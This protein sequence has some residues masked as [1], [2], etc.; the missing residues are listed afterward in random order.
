MRRAGFLFRS[1]EKFDRALH[2][3]SWS[4]ARQSEGRRS[5]KHRSRKHPDDSALPSR[6]RV[7]AV[8]PV[9]ETR[10]SKPKSRL[11]QVRSNA[12]RAS[13][14]FGLTIDHFL[15]PSDSLRSQLQAYFLDLR[16]E[17]TQ[18]SYAKDLKRFLQFLAARKHKTGGHEPIHRG[19]L[20]AYKD[21]L[22]TEGLEHTTI[23]RFLSMLR[24]L[25]RFLFEEG[26]MSENPAI[27]VR[28]LSPKRVSKTQAFTDQEVANVI[29]Q[30]NLHTRTGA[31]HHAILLLLFQCGLR[32]SELCALRTSQITSERGY[33]VMRLR[34][35]GNAERVIPL[36][37]ES[38]AALEYYYRIC[39]MSPDV[40]QPLFRPQK[41]NRTGN[42][43]KSLD[44][45]HIY[46]IVT[47]YSLMAGV[48]KRVSPHSC[49]ATAIS[50]ARDHAAPDR[51]IQEFAGW[52]TP[53]MITQYDK[54]KTAVTE[55]A[56]LLIDYGPI[57]RDS[58]I[59]GGHA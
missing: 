1:L 14:E 38:I 18:K 20:V 5:K 11:I 27:R 25:F 34:G 46:H 57:A 33:K 35:K 7:R 42:K 15:N 39:Q 24:S 53:N 6:S 36:R 48:A 21:S 50:N 16:S 13:K 45:S 29:A 3:V 43:E 44:P 8:A 9:K 26:A 55:S 19:L 41:N 12:P 22:L 31:M 30:P 10:Q 32:R 59:E 51:K 4:A 52:S 17:H 47:K 28:L 49:R 54:R 37:P 56:A 58:E 23:D 40:D 2:R